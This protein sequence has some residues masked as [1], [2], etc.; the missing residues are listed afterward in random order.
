MQPSHTPQPTYL[1][2]P[3]Q[4]FREMEARTLQLEPVIRRSQELVKEWTSVT[5]L[6]GGSVALRLNLPD[7]DIDL[8]LPCHSRDFPLIG[9]ALGQFCQFRG[10]RQCTPGSTRLLFC[11]KVGAHHIDVNVMRKEDAEHMLERIA[12]SQRDMPVG[13]RS[14]LLWRKWLSRN[15]STDASYEGLKVDFYERA[16]PGFTWKA[17]DQIRQELFNTNQI[18]SLNFDAAL[19]QYDLED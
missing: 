12:I 8:I 11:F 9:E 15:F 16:M 13:E 10:E 19:P 3:E 2:G 18:P 14:D 1:F 6:L 17:D 5:P 7:S 4:L